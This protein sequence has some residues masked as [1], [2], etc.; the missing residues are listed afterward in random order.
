M[1]CTNDFIQFITLWL[2]MDLYQMVLP[3]LQHSTVQIRTTSVVILSLLQIHSAIFHSLLH[4][5]TIQ[6]E[7][8][9]LYPDTNS[10]PFSA[11]SNRVWFVLI[12]Y[13]CTANIPQ[14]F[15]FTEFYSKN[16]F[17]FFLF[18]LW[19]RKGVKNCF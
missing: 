1:V 18:L 3:K 14:L 13:L 2:T 19:T 4:A 11:K 9:Q 17:F 5:K 15:N 10:E 6:L 16:L 12:C 8:Q 7:N